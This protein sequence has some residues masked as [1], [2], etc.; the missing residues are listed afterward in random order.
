LNPISTVKITPDANIKNIDIK[1]RGFVIHLRRKKY[2]IVNIKDIKVIT[3]KSG[4]ELAVS[5]RYFE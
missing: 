3:S 4:H 5:I 2:I 1:I